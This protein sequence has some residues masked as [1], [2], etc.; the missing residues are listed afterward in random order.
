MVFVFSNLVCTG[1]VLERFVG[2]GYT[3]ART[4]ES[5]LT[6]MWGEGSG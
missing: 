1:V 2:I 5:G 6:C 4:L 3:E